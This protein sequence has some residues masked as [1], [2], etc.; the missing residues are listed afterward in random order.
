MATYQ[1]RCAQDGDFEVSR[2][3]R[4]AA[5]QVRCAACGADAA[6]VF[7]SPMLSLAP[8][9]IVAAIDRAERTR[10]QPA[11]VSSLPPGRKQPKTARVRPTL[12]PLPRP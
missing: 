12:Q 10:D 4:M 5:P 3:I 11:L 1:Y 2:P 8:R 6:R 9:A 7:T